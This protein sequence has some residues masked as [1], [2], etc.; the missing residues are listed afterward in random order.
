MSRVEAAF[1]TE[2]RIVAIEAILPVK[3]LTFRVKNSRRYR[4]IADSIAETGIIEPP[5]ESR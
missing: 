5:V 2:T 4:M 1:E 3:R